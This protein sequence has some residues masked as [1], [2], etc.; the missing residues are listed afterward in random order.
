M[1]KV[2]LITG[3]ARSGKSRVAEELA[4]KHGEP[5]LYIATAACGDSEMKERIAR[6]QERRGPVWQTIEE[7]SDLAG[8]LS[9]HEGW[10]KAVLVDCVTLWLT[11][12]LLKLECKEAVLEEVMRTASIFPDLKTP[13]IL[14]SN[15][16]G[17]GI[18]PDNPLARTFCDLSGEANEILAKAADEVYVTFSGLPLKLK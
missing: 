11:N 16:T 3:G 13:V 6:H 2:I 18:V 7:Q 17:M 10:F 4:L 15:E 8:V 1:S 14:V 5:L 12:L 9:G